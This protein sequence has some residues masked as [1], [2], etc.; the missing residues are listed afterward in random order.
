MKI[1]EDVYSDVGGKTFVNGE[2][3]K[4]DLTPI[5]YTT[6]QLVKYTRQQVLTSN[7]DPWYLYIRNVPRGLPEGNTRVLAGFAAGVYKSCPVMIEDT[8]WVMIICEDI[9]ET[10]E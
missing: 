10:I 5:E 9:L 7:R 8:N 3:V 4:T 1:G 2:Q 6:L